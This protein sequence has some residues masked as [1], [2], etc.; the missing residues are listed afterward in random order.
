MDDRRDRTK[1]QGT[2]TSISTKKNTT[3]ISITDSDM[4]QREEA[5]AV[6]TN[7]N[8]LRTDTNDYLKVEISLFC[9]NQLSPPGYSLSESLTISTVWK[10]LAIFW[11]TDSVSRFWAARFK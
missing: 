4:P 1:F 7:R 8:R 3:F 2:I 6:L 9:K 11:K 5:T 10:L